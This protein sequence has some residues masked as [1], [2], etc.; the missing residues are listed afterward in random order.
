MTVR[1]MWATKS[2]LGHDLNP[3][4]HVA[5]SRGRVPRRL[6]GFVLEGVPIITTLTRTEV[7]QLVPAAERLSWARTVARA[8][9]PCRPA[10]VRYEEA[11]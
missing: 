4:E 1:K 5:L 2:T 7:E 11:S 6:Y 10:N 3:V 8:T 9:P